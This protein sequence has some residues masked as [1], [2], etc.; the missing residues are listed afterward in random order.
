[1][2]LKRIITAFGGLALVAGLFVFTA[3]GTSAATS[4]ANIAKSQLEH[5]SKVGQTAYKP[6]PANLTEGVLKSGAPA[7]F[8]DDPN[9][10]R[11]QA[12]VMGPGTT[13]GSTSFPQNA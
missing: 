2:R 7:A 8:T 11:S 5:A 9:L 1:M 4:T 10:V 3:A 13:A 6:S 12:G